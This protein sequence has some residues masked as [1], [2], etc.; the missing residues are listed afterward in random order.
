[1]NQGKISPGEYALHAMGRTGEFHLAQWLGENGYVIMYGPSGSTRAPRGSPF[2]VHQPT[3]KGL[4]IIAFRPADG[5][6]LILD[7]KAGGDTGSIGE[8]GAFTNELRGKLQNRIKKIEGMR[9]GLP[10]PM[11][12]HVDKV[13]NDLRAAD[14]ALAKQKGATWPPNV[15]LAVANAGGEA[16]GVTPGLVKQ[17]KARGIRNVEFINFNPPRVQRV[18]LASGAKPQA[19]RSAVRGSLTKLSSGAKLGLTAL[20]F[21]GTTLGLL[22]AAHA[23]PGLSTA[24]QMANPRGLVQ[25]SMLEGLKNLPQ[26]KA[27]PRT[28]ASYFS[29]PNTFRGIRAIDLMNKHLRPFAQE[30]DKHHQQVM[31]TAAMEIYGLAAMAK[32]RPDTDR[33]EYLGDLNAEL[34]DYARDLDVIDDNLEAAQ[35]L[36]GP[37]L[38][39]A[40][41]AQQLAKGADSLIVQDWLLKQGGLDYNQIMDMRE[42]LRD[43]A[44]VVPRVFGD[45]DALRAQVERQRQRLWDLRWEI[46]KLS[47]GIALAPLIDGTSAP[48][49]PD[50]ESKDRDTVLSVLPWNLDRAIPLDEIKRRVRAARTDFIPSVEKVL[51]DLEA[52]NE[53][54]FMHGPGVRHGKVW[55]RS[56][57]PAHR[58]QGD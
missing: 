1:M 26:P 50:L 31:A 36:S 27:D 17:L 54:N 20:G 32:D 21:A 11:M 55:Y 40:A 22:N 37:A 7:N 46:S 43:F 13:L 12:D 2:R 44:A 15:A 39:A 51:A 48:P 52:R 10:A 56:S 29:D 53:V 25:E 42:T 14:Q 19:S 35:E 33:I 24:A 41:G 8:V 45:V 30:L 47:W 49:L 4:D 38:S 6:I 57:A 28:A 16:R 5:S 18:V 9:Q 23:S 58:P 3:T 34:D